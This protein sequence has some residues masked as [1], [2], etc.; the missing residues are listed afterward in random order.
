MQEQRMHKTFPHVLRIEPAS[1]CNLSCAH[2][3]TG[4]IEIPRGIMSDEIFLRVLKDVKENQKFIKVIVLYHGGEPLLNKN[5]F[6]YIERLKSIKSDFYI[7]T[8]SNGMAINEKIADKILQ[9]QLDLIEFSLDG[10]SAL[11]SEYVRRQSKTKKIVENIQLLIEKRNEIGN[12]KLKIA[13][14]STQ[15]HRNKSAP[16]VMPASVPKWL[17]EIFN[18]TVI[19]SANYA[20]KWPHMAD[21]GEFD[22]LNTSGPDTNACDH[23]ESTITVRSDGSVVPCCYDLTTQLPMGNIQNASLREIWSGNKYTELRN[24]IS[25]G[26][27][28][29]ICGDCATVKQPIYLVPKWHLKLENSR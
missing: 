25:S 10:N 12:Q 16:P 28:I 7:K 11:E 27:F 21:I 26:K 4:T 2:C 20:L 29:S 19:Y 9:S 15:F 1:K 17:K 14:V 6:K 8:V 13:I 5:F 18:D 24:S 22:F 23:V 3:P